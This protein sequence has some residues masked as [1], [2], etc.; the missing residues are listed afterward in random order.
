MFLRDNKLSCFELQKNQ[1]GKIQN[2]IPQGQIQHEAPVLCSDIASDGITT[3]SSGCDGQIRMWNVTQ[4]STPSSIQVIGKHDQPVFALK[5]LTEKNILVS[6]SWDKSIKFWD[7]R[8]P[9]PVQ[10]FNL[11]SKILAM[12]AKAD[13][14]VAGT[15]DKNF[16]VYNLSNMS[17]VGQFK[18]PLTYQLRCMSIFSDNQG[19]AAGC[20]EGRITFEYFNEMEMKMRQPNN[21]KFPNAKSFVFKCHR[22][23]NDIYSVN[24]V[25]FYKN[26][27]LVS[28][29][30][31]GTISFWNKDIKQRLGSYELFKLKSPITCAK[32]TPNGEALFYSLSY[33]WSKGCNQNLQQYN[34]LIYMHPIAEQEMLPR[35]K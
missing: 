13:I 21:S 28:A 31:D 30:S 9:N 11:T 6:S 33:D 18:S 7:C 10:S 16:L 1:M 12:D 2:A 24:A 34:N 29:G 26:N 27:V 20:I 8:Q 14:L 19:F 25:D 32:F 4:G 35:S 5:F 17:L 22:V 23:D 3:F 15:E